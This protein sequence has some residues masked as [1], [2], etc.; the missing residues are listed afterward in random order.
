MPTGQNYQA[1]SEQR[2]Q[3]EVLSG[4]GVPQD[5][6]SE[7]IGCAPKT[8]REH[9]R[10]ELDLGKAKANAKIAQRLFAKAMDGDTT[11]L[12]YWTKSQMGWSERSRVEISGPDGGPV[13]TEVIR[14]V[15][16]DSKITEGGDAKKMIDRGVLS[17]EEVRELIASK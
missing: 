3:V 9:Y 15:I 2:L 17:P 8:L 16:V 11:C 10:R 13:Q 5:A 14:R 4:Y 1:T 12:I 7:I 6:I